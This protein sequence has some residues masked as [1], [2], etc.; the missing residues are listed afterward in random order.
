M[1]TYLYT[2]KDTLACRDS[3]AASCSWK[4]ASASLTAT[5][6]RFRAAKAGGDAAR[7]MMLDSMVVAGDRLP[8]ASW[9]A[10]STCSA[11]WTLSAVYYHVVA[12][13]APGMQE[14]LQPCMTTVDMI[15]SAGHLHTKEHADSG[16]A[17]LAAAQSDTGT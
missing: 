9:A 11:C 5:T 4:V 12:A 7:V 10:R 6:L 2:A 1:L 8:A 13:L 16:L 17:L 15:S 3:W 14:Q